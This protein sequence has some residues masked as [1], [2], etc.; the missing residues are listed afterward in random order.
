MTF[1]K[2]IPERAE[3]VYLMVF[4]VAFLLALV[5]TPLCCKLSVKWGILDD[6]GQR[7]IHS[8]PI[9]LLGGLAVFMA[10]MGTVLLGYFGL[11]WLGEKCGLGDFAGG[12]VKAA[13]RLFVILFGGMLMVALGMRD[14]KEDLHAGAKFAGQFVVALFVAMSGI[15]LTLFIDNL[16][17][18][19]LITVLWI[20]TVTNAFNFFDNMDGL[21]GGVGFICAAFF[22]L[23]AAINGQFFVCV[24]AMAF[25]GALLGFLPFNWSP[26]RIFLGD[27][28]SHFV[29]YM[30]SVLTVLATFYAS[31]R[32]SALAVIIPLIVLCVPLFDM[33]AVSVIRIRHGQPVYRGDV[34][35]ISHRFVR[36]GL[37]K[38]VAV[39]VICLIVFTLGLSALILLWANIWTS[40]VVLLQCA[41]FLLV[42]TILENNSQRGSF[43]HAS[44]KEAPGNPPVVKDDKLL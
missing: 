3:L 11:L 43:P 8:H 27:A 21:C 38:P 39:V 5:F 6:P 33:L 29:G 9:P 28:G 35:H 19:Y 17:L 14:D 13:S 22:G 31:N 36:A 12:A 34:N 1:L 2:A 20:V 40:L 44:K 32:H 7:K 4:D 30:L 26:A 41:A 24:L 23:V 16:F 18:S 42:V 37:S 25:C 10:F 15:R